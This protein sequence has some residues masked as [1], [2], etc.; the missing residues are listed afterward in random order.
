MKKSVLTLCVFVLLLI[1]NGCNLDEMEFSK[2]SKEINL[3]PEFVAPIAK[4]NITAWDLVQS[5]NK[6]NE[7]F[8]Q[9]DST[10]L[11]KIVYKKNDLIKYKVAD[12]IQLPG[13]PNFSSGNKVIGEVSTADIF[14][15][16]SISLNDLRGKVNGA[17][18]GIV[19]FNGQKLP[20]PQVT[21]SDLAADFNLAALSNFTTIT[22]SKGT[23][24][25]TLENKLKVPLTIY[26][27]LFD[28]GNNGIVT[29]FTFDDI[30]ANGTKTFTS[31]LA[32]VDLTNQVEFRMTTFHT[33][34]PS[35]TPVDIDLKDYFKLTFNLTNLSVSKGRLMI[36]KTQS[37]ESSAG[38][39]EINFPEPDLKAF[40]VG[41]KK[42]SLTFNCVNTSQMNGSVNIKLNE[43]KKDGVPL[44]VDIPLNG[45]STTID[46]TGAV[47]NFSANPLFPFNRI[48][49][50]QTLTINSTPGYID[51]LSTDAIKLDVSMNDVEYNTFEGDF[52][53]R[54]IVVDKN[55]FD[56]NL[57]LF[58]KIT[59]NFK[60]ANPSMV[61]TIHNS[62]G[63]PGTI[64]LD[65]SASNKDG[66]VVPLKTSP[67][68][69]PVPANINAGM[70][71]KDIILNKTNSQIV[72]FIALPPTGNISYSGQVDF[73]KKSAVTVQNPNFINMDATFGIDLTM[74]L[75]LELQINKLGF[76]DTTGISGSSFT[77]F[78]SADLIVNALNGIPLDIDIQLLYIDTI[79]KIQYGASKGTRIL[80]AAQVNSNGGITPVQST[81][82]FSLTKG[83]MD[84][85]RK[86]NGIIFSGTVNSPAA[87]ATVASLYSDSEIKLNV[88]IK[89]KIKL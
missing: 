14:I 87:G 4:A 78:E 28:V 48:P 60:L 52:G 5:A 86:A 8:F 54:N 50:V 26:G 81:Q 21:A 17:L 88:V 16:T 6:G 15:S 40:G 30:P 68:D 73:N 80:S 20:F 49:Y 33:P 44:V 82:T 7:G 45:N 53:V 71:S 56:M 61:L 1:F 37:L 31:S 13:S 27:N 12:L 38:E 34:G 67:F 41:L 58:D 25:I 59:G 51:F 23:I 65:L 75:P 89:P 35:L 18:D 3:N 39:F 84:N 70:A 43:I 69:I 72:D 55:N 79:S 24:E 85:L 32:G 76:K 47:I 36:A 57:E 10:G 46:L 2:L 11:I 19:P 83:D 9:Q 42:G 62:I 77:D 74:E 66:L 64:S 29:S 22:L 63:I